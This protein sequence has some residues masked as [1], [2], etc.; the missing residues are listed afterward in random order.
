MYANEPLSNG[1]AFPAAIAGLPTS[2]GLLPKYRPSTSRKP[3]R[4]VRLDLCRVPPTLDRQSVGALKPVR[5][6]ARWSP[7]G[8]TFA[9]DRDLQGEVVSRRI[10]IALTRVIDLSKLITLGHR[11]ARAAATGV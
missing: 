5:D 6:L 1:S 8:L 9:G 2:T 11:R 7:R 3:P 4:D 10:R